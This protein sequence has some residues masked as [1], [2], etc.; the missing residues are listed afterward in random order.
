VGV[1]ELSTEVKVPQTSRRQKG[2]MK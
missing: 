1:H 2:D